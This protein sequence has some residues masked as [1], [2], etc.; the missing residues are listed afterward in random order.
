MPKVQSSKLFRFLWKFEFVSG[1][2]V[3]PTLYTL[4]EKLELSGSS[5]DPPKS[6]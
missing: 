2:G 1:I 6:D 5:L 3:K 4:Q